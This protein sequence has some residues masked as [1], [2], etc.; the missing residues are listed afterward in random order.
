MTAAR[1][2]F[3]PRPNTQHLIAVSLWAFLRQV[4][5]EPKDSQALK[6]LVALFLSHYHRVQS[7]HQIKPI[8]RELPSE[9]R[10]AATV[11]IIERNLFLCLEKRYV[12]AS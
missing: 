9:Q 2:G 6:A 4:E 1:F 10:L 5:P 7:V 11:A 8:V 3:E 12:L